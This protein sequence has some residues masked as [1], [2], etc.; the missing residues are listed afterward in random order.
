MDKIYIVDAVNYLFRSYYAIGPMMNDKGESTSAVFGF[1]RSLQKL[2]KDCS[3]SHLVCVFDGPDNKKSRKAVYAEYKMNRKGAPED[4]FPQFEWANEWCQMVGIPTLCVDGVEADDTMAS[5]ALWAQKKG[6]KVFLC[7]SD[8]DLAQLVNDQVFVLHTHKENAILD[9]MK[10]KEIFGVWPEQML[11]YLAMVGD[12]S[13]NIPGISGFGPKTAASLLEEFGTLDALL[14]HPEKV[15]GEKKQELLKS[16][17]KTALM[18]RELATLNCSVEIPQGID[19]YAI[20]NSDPTKLTAFY[21]RMKFLSLLREME[22]LPPPKKKEVEPPRKYHLIDDEKS[23]SALL[24]NLENENELCIDTETTD[25]SPMRA[26]LVGIGLAKKGSDVWYIPFN[27]KLGQEKALSALKELFKSPRLKVFGHNI[28][29]DLHVLQNAGFS[30]PEIS[31]DTL[32]ASYLLNP[33]SRRH[34]LD[35]LTLEK[36]QKQK[37]AITDLIGKGKEEISMREVAVEKVAEYCCEDVD[38]TI[39]LKDLFLDELKERHLDRLLFDI[40]LPLLPVLQKMERDGIYLDTEELR[41]ISTVLLNDIE[42]LKKEI[43]LDA[44]EEI[45]L[46]SPKQLSELLFQKLG[47][48]SPF[49]GK[50]EFSTSADVLEAMIQDHPIIP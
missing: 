3:P 21:Q 22:N 15:K 6:S 11:D 24:Q 43:F 28:K 23:L 35:E 19:F 44:K 39:R 16:E 34:N 20:K 46:N 7:S 37:I 4:L 27:G 29:Y 47:L 12:A 49:R 30:L 13:D 5:I 17:Q 41:S 1:I 50:T 38:Y 48:K 2:I 18:S 42:T 40:E 33:Q 10:V 9:R 26:E 25:T 8:K 14:S 32:V 36:F 31:F 45:N